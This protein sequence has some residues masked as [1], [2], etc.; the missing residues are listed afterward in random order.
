MTVTPYY[1]RDGI[2]IFNADCRDVLPTIDPATVALVLT[3]PPYGIG[4]DDHGSHPT[5][6]VI[7]DHDQELGNEVVTFC[8][9]HNWPLI[10][11]ASPMK[12]WHGAWRQHLVW[13]KGGAVGGGGDIATCWKFTWELIQ[14][15]GTGR[16]NGQRD[17]AVLQHYTTPADMTLHPCQKPVPL[18]RYLIQKTTQ[19]SDVVIDPFMGSGSVARACMD[20]GRCYIGIELSEAYCEIAVSRLSQTVLPLEIPA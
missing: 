10:V 17:S 8:R 9:S 2:T 14:V 19:P 6:S 4:L 12:P 15:A 13:D 18:L 11:F 7:G 5:W 20:T 1:D 3:D 16:L